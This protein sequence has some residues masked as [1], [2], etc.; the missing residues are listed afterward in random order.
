[1]VQRVAATAVDAATSLLV[2]S[3]SENT[4]PVNSGGPSVRTVLEI[5]QDRSPDSS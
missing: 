3:A 4:K 2:Q 1:M 5:I